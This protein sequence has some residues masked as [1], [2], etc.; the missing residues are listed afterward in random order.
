MSDY[1]EGDLIRPLGQVTLY[2]GYA[3]A[4]VNL[5]L[6]MLRDC[7]VRVEVSAVA[8]LGQ[9]L[10]EMA[11][12]VRRLTGAAAAEVLGI[13][14]ESKQLIDRRNLLVH[15]SV[16]AQGRV[17]P[18]D[19]EK[20]EF[21]VTPEALTDLAEQAFN[22]KERLNAAVQLRLLPELRE[23]AINGTKATMTTDTETKNPDGQDS[24]RLCDLSH[25]RCVI[26]WPNSKLK[27]DKFG[28]GEI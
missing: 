22:W 13:L 8:P 20:S 5:L 26:A 18:N 7:G 24:W 9:R 12:A 23:T 11:A 27:A 3:E 15:A 28:R 19:S 21:R 10:A 4:Q 6:V 17:T 14:E 16:L 1:F 25:P 2:F